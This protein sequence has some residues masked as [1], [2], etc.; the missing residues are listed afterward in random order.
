MQKLTKIHI[1]LITAKIVSAAKNYKTKMR[2]ILFFILREIIADECAKYLANYPDYSCQPNSASLLD[3]KANLFALN[4]GD[5][6]Y[7]LRKL[8]ASDFVKK[9]VQLLTQLKVI[10][11]KCFFKFDEIFLLDDSFFFIYPRE[12][13]KPLPAEINKGMNQ[14]HIL[15]TFGE[16]AACLSIVHSKLIVYGHFSIHNVVIGEDGRVMITSPFITEEE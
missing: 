4:K 12:T 8:P 6:P 1:K 9:R 14:L 11:D 7:E 13:L 2:M 3:P 5:K 15:K 16:I 10:D